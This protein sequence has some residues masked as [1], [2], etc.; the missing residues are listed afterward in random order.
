MLNRIQLSID[1][2]LGK[3]V[4][5]ELPSCRTYMDESTSSCIQSTEE[6]LTYIMNGLWDIAYGY[7]D[8]MMGTSVDSCRS[9]SRI[10]INRFLKKFISKMSKGEL[11]WLKKLVD[12]KLIESNFH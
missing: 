8:D 5:G 2:A 9:I 10:A 7:P 12:T 11:E 3:L 4:G 1:D 6:L